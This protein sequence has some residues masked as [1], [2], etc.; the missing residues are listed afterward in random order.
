VTTPFVEELQR[1]LA[2]RR[3][4][5]RKL[6]ELT[7]YHP[8]WLSKIRNGRPPSAEVVR[9]CDEVLGAGGTLV[10]LAEASELRPAHLPAAPAGF[11]GREAELGRMR[12]ALTVESQMG[13]PT[14]VAVDGPPG[15]GKTATALRCAHEVKESEEWN[16]SDGELFA[17]LHGHSPNEGPARPE[18][19][20]EEFLIALGVPAAEIPVGLE[21]RTKL[22][23]TL[24][25]TRK[26]LIVLD[27]AA[28]SEQVERLLPG[29]GNCGV[30]VTSRRRLVGLAMRAGAVRVVLG[31][32]T[33]RESIALLRTFI[34]GP[35]ADAEPDSIVAL[36]RRCG[37]L[38]M[39]L[40]IAAER[41]A[42]HPY[43]PVGELVD[44][45]NSDERPLD[46][47]ATDDSVAMRTVFESS[48]RNLDG[49]EARVFRLLGL[50]RGP[51]ISMETAS[52]LAELPAVRA[53]RLLEKLVSVHLLEAAPAGR[54]HLH[55][56]LHM[57]AVERVQAEHDA[58]DRKSSV[59]RLV[60]W[61]LHTAVAGSRVLA[62]FRQRQLE[63]DPP[64]AGIVPRSFMNHQQTL[65]WF[66]AE[67]ANFHPVIKLALDNGFHDTAWRLAVVLREY[68]RLRRRPLRW[69]PDS[70]ELALT[71]A[72]AAGDRRAEGQVTTMAAEAQRWLRHYDQAG[73]L[74]DGALTIRQEAG[75][76]VG[77]AWALAESGFLAVEQEQFE[78]AY[79]FASK[80]LAIFQDVGDRHGQ[81]SALFT[82]ADAYDGWQRHGD[83]LSALRDALKIF[84]EIGDHDGAG[85]VLVKMAAIHHAFDE[86]E[87]ALDYLD[88]ALEARRTAGSRWGE[89]DCLCRLASVLHALGR[90][91][92]VRKP[93]ED[94]LALYDE[95]DDPRALDLRSCLD[96]QDYGM[97][98]KLLPNPAF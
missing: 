55:D 60:D 72:R 92:E 77:E 88:L 74:L 19:L 57:Y 38:P 64:S 66:D 83:A 8:S 70:L 37:N 62:P 36:A 7:G 43:R 35:R 3:F 90:V 47:L 48:Y 89:A 21:L 50:Q 13:V 84:R 28:S 97:V 85:L 65:G 17:D 20:L 98:R 39:A 11:I 49:A 51:E 1:L 78:Q 31:P 67:S 52:V 80:A 6:A 46:A 15:V 71:A 27:N 5:W 95:I 63:L 79:P 24:L 42:A 91:E 73:E 23:R 69:W 4:S 59:R 76:L 41:V 75:D 34:G 44:E 32:T 9:R 45:L 18:D 12:D 87:K 10:A 54:Y 86:P 25:G 2:E 29:S 26:V 96:W 33:T 93:C 56:L 53:R 14:I 58:E 22:Y 82:L 61:Y 40:R 68:A 94:A 16:Y 81:A 30:I